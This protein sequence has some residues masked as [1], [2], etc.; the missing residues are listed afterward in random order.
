MWNLVICE[1]FDSLL[2]AFKNC[3]MFG[4]QKSW[5]AHASFVNIEFLRWFPSIALRISTAHDFR[6]IS[7]RIS[8]RA[9][10]NVSNF[11]QTKLDSEVNAPFLL[12]EHGDP[13]FLFHNF[14]EN[15]IL[16]NW[17]KY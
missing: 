4:W 11:P 9:R 13:Y 7:A 12:N 6:V 2:L 16:S 1:I 17:E 3:K 8:A 5:W 10:K 14:N 15:N